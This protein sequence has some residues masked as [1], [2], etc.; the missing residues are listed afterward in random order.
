MV[1]RLG[2]GRVRHLATADL[3]IQQ[4]IRNG[5]FSVAKYPTVD[6]CADLMTKVKGRSDM[7]HLLQLMGFAQMDGRSQ[8]APLRFKGWDVSKVVSSPKDPL[9][10]PTSTTTPTYAMQSVDNE[11]GYH[12]SQVIHHY[13]SHSDLLEGK[14]LLPSRALPKAGK[15]VL[16]S[17]LN[18]NSGEEMLG[19]DCDEE[20]DFHSLVQGENHPLLL[21]TWVLVDTIT[22]I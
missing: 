8:I 21:A 22:T 12:R 19:T 15:R 4:G 9:Q 6:N 16:H 20:P 1:R 2:L 5:S 11:P 3:W 13:P 10:L 17:L 18:L 14:R 7:W